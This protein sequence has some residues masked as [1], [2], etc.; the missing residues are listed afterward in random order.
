MK[1]V[2]ALP[3]ERKD[4]FK[5]KY[6]KTLRWNAEDK[7][8]AWIGREGLPEDLKEFLAGPTTLRLSAAELGSPSNSCQEPVGFLTSETTL[9]IKNGKRSPGKCPVAP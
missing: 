6:G 4:E 3:Y 5:Q 8:W 2:L 1:M 7:V 9:A